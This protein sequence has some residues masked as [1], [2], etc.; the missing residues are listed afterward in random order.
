MSIRKYIKIPDRKYALVMVLI[1]A[2]LFLHMPVHAQNGPCGWTDAA[3]TRET[4]RLMYGFAAVGAALWFIPGFAV[5]AAILGGIAG[6]TD[7]AMTMSQC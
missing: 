5:G 7:I 6:A 3:Q 4:I 1:Y 2:L